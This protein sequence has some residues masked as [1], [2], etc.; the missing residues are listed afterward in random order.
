[1]IEYYGNP[2]GK[3]F[4]SANSRAP[5]GVYFAWHPDTQRGQWVTPAGLVVSESRITRPM[6]VTE[7]WQRVSPDVLNADYGMDLGL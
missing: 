2:S 3:P 1:M 6:S 5:S 4:V 7:R